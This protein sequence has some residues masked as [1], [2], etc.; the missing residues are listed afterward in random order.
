MADEGDCSVGSQRHAHRFTASIESPKRKIVSAAYNRRTIFRDSGEKVNRVSLLLSCLPLPPHGFCSI[1]CAPLVIKGGGAVVVCLSYVICF[2][3][4]LLL[5][6][7]A[8]GATSGS[9]EGW[10]FL[11]PSA[12]F[13]CE[14]SISNL[15]FPFNNSRGNN[16][17]VRKACARPVPQKIDSGLLSLR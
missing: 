5:L 7:F 14:L 17:R 3:H 6:T 9:V 1:I 4:V 15:T 16:R 10:F 13:V 2:S 12:G 11:L 8:N